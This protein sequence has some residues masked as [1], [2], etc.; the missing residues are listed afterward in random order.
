MSN[1]LN[2]SEVQLV[3]CKS[4]ASDK[5]NDNETEES[6]TKN[7]CTKKTPTKQIFSCMNL[8]SKMEKSML[9]DILGIINNLY[10]NGEINNDEKIQLKK[11]IITKSDK[12]S[13]LYKSYHINDL[14]FINEL[15]KLIV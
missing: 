13:K 10:K 1:F 6:E 7:F 15:K 9:K 5:M 4:N 3:F 11:L 14:K 12:I 2:D 8:K